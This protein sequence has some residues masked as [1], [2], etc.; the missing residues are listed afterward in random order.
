MG[1]KGSEPHTRRESHWF[2]NLTGLRLD[3]TYKRLRKILSAIKIEIAVRHG[4]S[5]SF[6]DQSAGCRQ[7]AVSLLD[8]KLHNIRGHGFKDGGHI[9]YPRSTKPLSPS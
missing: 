2:D 6:L 5:D 3:Q 7:Y 9:G 4:Y 1:S 8:P